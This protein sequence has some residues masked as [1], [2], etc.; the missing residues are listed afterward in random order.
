MLLPY[1]GIIFSKALINYNTRTNIT[2]APV[3]YFFWTLCFHLNHNG[4]P[5]TRV[6]T[7]EY[8]LSLKQTVININVL[9]PDSKK[10]K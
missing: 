7:P 3:T 9:Q 6:Q 4:E 10:N 5:D 8:L 1:D 2:I